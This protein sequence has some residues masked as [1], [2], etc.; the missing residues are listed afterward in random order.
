MAIG[1]HDIRMVLTHIEW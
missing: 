1:L